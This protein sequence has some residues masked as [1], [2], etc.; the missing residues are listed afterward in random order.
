M[1]RPGMNPYARPKGK[2]GESP[3]PTN[4]FVFGGFGAYAVPEPP[5]SSDPEYTTSYSPEL[6]RGGS[7]DGTKLPDDIRVGTREEPENDP[8]D[9]QYNR[10]RWSNKLRRHSVEETTTGW[11]VQ[12][13]TAGP[14]AQNPM[15]SQPRL[16]IRPT[17]NNSPLNYQFQRPWYVPRNVAEIDPALATEQRMHFSLADHRRTYDIM[18]MQP[19]G[20]VGVNTYRATPQPWDEDLFI[21]PSAPNV[22]DNGFAGNRTFRLR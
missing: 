2:D 5:D 15:W 8:N 4:E 12:Q 3:D 13:E 16:P 11:N 19:R 14:P 6:Q 20:G 1:A 17:A 21:P 22:S 9:R 10:R 18:G 7:P